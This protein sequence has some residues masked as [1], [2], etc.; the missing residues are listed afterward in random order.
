MGESESKRK[1]SKRKVKNFRKICRLQSAKNLGNVITIHR[2]HVRL[3][4]P[5]DFKNFFLE[6]NRFHSNQVNRIKKAKMDD[7]IEILDEIEVTKVVK[8][9]AY[10]PKPKAPPKR[11]YKQAKSKPISL[12]QKC[13]FC[14]LSF[15][16]KKT[17]YEHCAFKHY[18]NYLEKEMKRYFKVHWDCT[19]C[20]EELNSAKGALMHIAI[21]R[22][23]VQEYLDTQLKPK[24]V[25]DDD[26]EEISDDS[27]IE[28]L[29]ACSECGTA[30][31]SNSQLIDVNGKL[32]CMP[33]IDKFSKI[34]KQQKQQQKQKA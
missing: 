17:Y 22:S 8:N 34:Q 19:V 26:V 7:E 30:Q 24:K 10:K 9:P 33:F 2:N 4:L 14:K 28:A 6:R 29:D 21:T 20:Y 25:L 13:R 5:P 23:L 18:R 16:N 15:D 31:D 11:V 1:T 32:H 3:R 12:L 27:E